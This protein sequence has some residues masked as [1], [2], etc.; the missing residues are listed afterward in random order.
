MW[1]LIIIVL[2]IMIVSMVRL[3]DKAEKINHTLT[4]VSGSMGVG[5]TFFCSTIAIKHYK[6]QLRKYP[7]A[8]LI[9]SIPLRYRKGFKWYFSTPLQ[10][11]HILKIVKIPEGSVVFIDEFNTLANQYSWNQE[12]TQKYIL[13]F[14]KYFRHDVNGYMIINDQTLE[15][16]PKNVR[17]RCGILYNIQ[18]NYSRFFGLV[19]VFKCLPF[20]STES[21]INTTIDLT[22]KDIKLPYFAV[23]R[24]FKRLYDHRC[25]SE[26]YQP[27]MPATDVKYTALKAFKYN[28]YLEEY[29]EYKKY[30]K[31]QGLDCE[32]QLG[33]TLDTSY[34]KTV[35]KG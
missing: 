16:I 2:I 7:K 19:Q 14:V 5:K 17:S 22:D 31:S 30:M 11:E 1:F 34:N 29:K 8:Q 25:Y 23:F 10:I 3:F 33:T 12:F 9:S 21:G 24:P 26:L 28:D 6:K 13:N 18:E 35:E 15:D 20:L 4:A 32:Q 27:S